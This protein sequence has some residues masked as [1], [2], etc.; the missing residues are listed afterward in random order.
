MLAN[1]HTGHSPPLAALKPSFTDPGTSSEEVLSQKETRLGN[2]PAMS[3]LG[4]W[5]RPTAVAF[6]RGGSPP[7]DD[8]L[9]AI[10]TWLK[11]ALPWAVLS[12]IPK[13]AHE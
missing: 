10:L 1:C 12:S 9:R 2:P 5:A 4:L 7:W 11:S 8:V 13:A 3:C 6:L